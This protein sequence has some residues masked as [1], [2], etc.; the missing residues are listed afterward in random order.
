MLNNIQDHFPGQFEPELIKQIAV[1]GTMKSIRTGEVIMEIGSYV[2]GMPLVVKGAIKILRED[3]DGNELLLYFLEKGDTCAMTLTCCV[4]QSRSQVRAI[5]ELDTEIIL[6]PIQHMEE[7]LKYKTWR[8][9]VFES[10][11]S[12]LYEMLDAIDTLAFMNMHERLYKYLQNKAM[13]QKEKMLVVSHQQIAYDLNTSR[14]VISR[15]LK[16]LE[17]EE[18]VKLHRNRMEIL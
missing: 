10:Y 5:A 4:G 11:N 2:K 12:R 9:F 15:L 3:K 16:Q 18:K 6:L 7:W 14:V 1:S 8:D 17:T 13:I